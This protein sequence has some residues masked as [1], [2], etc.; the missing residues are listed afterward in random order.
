MWDSK[1]SVYKII[2]PPQAFK[3]KTPPPT[4]KELVRPVP[5]VFMS[6]NQRQIIH[7]QL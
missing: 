7:L 4:A 2:K 6:A 3:P 5:P 1:E